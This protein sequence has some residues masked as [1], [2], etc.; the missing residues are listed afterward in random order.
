MREDKTKNVDAENVKDSS[1][2][3][4]GNKDVKRNS[5][6]RGSKKGKPANN[7]K[8][9][10][11]AGNT[12]GTTVQSRAIFE[13]ITNSTGRAFNLCRDSSKPAHLYSVPGLAR[14]T[15]A[16]TIGVSYGAASA[17]NTMCQAMSNDL[18]AVG[19]Y[20]R[21]YDPA[22]LGV[23]LAAV[24]SVNAWYHY[25]RR[26]V[27]TLHVIS[28]SNMYYPKTLLRAMLVDS[29]L[30]DDGPEIG[31]LIR[32][33]N[34]TLSVK[35]SS[36]FVPAGFSAFNNYGDLFGSL[37][38]EKEELGIKSQ[39]YMF[40]PHG[41]HV[42]TPTD[43]DMPG[44][45]T[46]YT[47]HELITMAKKARGVNT[48][49]D[50]FF[51]KVEDMEWITNFMLGKIFNQ[52]D[53]N[54]IAQDIR[55]GLKDSVA[56][57]YDFVGDDTLPYFQTIPDELKIAIRNMDILGDI[58]P[59]SNSITQ[60]IMLD[61][62][63]D[64]NYPYSLPKLTADMDNSDAWAT[65][66]AESHLGHYH[67]LALN[68]AGGEEPDMQMAACRFKLHIQKAK[69]GSDSYYEDKLHN[70]KGGYYIL[71]CG[72]EIVTRLDIFTLE[73][74]P[75][76]PLRLKGMDEVMIESTRWDIKHTNNTDSMYQIL[77]K[78]LTYYPMPILF[79]PVG[80]E[81]T[82]NF[83]LPLGTID[84]YTTLADTALMAA[85]NMITELVW[86]GSVLAPK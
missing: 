77:S 15:V 9:N 25:L 26:I 4:G 74:D 65:V 38:V 42:Y 3:T 18:R 73:W 16:P 41:F 84:R 71:S 10:G 19:K 17:F 33:M 64:K 12:R 47:L 81:D 23:Y 7:Y 55:E 36:M 46:Y 51:M 75:Q 76:N 31:D 27:G 35:L 44:S 28:S 82:S 24:S 68:G 32:H 60:R 34:N 79:T 37:Y 72:S 21:S 48:S 22:D 40:H 52:Q 66:A 86:Y 61:F 56:L 39:M 49:T 2:S 20:N 58:E 83:W 29:S 80:M 53:V 85:H 62:W 11:T 67:F 8:S 30:S 70:A 50:D 43:K 57:Q 59:R 78:F 54:N 63:D 13:N 14:F 45:A 6:N 1:E 5:R 69:K